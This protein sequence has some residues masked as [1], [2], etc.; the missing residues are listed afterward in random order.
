MT[1]NENA[2]EKKNEIIQHWDFAVFTAEKGRALSKKYHTPENGTPFATLV[3]RQSKEVTDPHAAT[4][5]H[6]GKSVGEL[7][8]AQLKSMWKDLQVVQMEVS[9]KA[10]ANRAAKGYQLETYVL[11]KKG[12]VDFG[13][14][15]DID[16]E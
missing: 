8:K 11:C 1:Q 6:F 3:C 12:T 14:E 5:V 13:E 2:T 9:P 15:I 10:L 16:W 7:D 4:Y